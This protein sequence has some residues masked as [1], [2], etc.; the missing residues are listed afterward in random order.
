MK[1]DWIKE[2]LGLTTACTRGDDCI[3]PFEDGP[4]RFLLMTIKGA[5]ALHSFKE[6]WFRVESQE[7]SEERARRCSPFEYWSGFYVWPFAE[8]PR[9]KGLFEGSAQNRIL[10]I[11]R[12]L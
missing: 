12:R 9:A 8:S 1:K 7:F 11:E 2:R 4:N 3:P 5:L 6:S 10:Q